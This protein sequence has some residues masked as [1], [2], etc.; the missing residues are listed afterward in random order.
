MPPVGGIGKNS[1]CKGNRSGF[2]TAIDQCR[3]A[4]RRFGAR[5]GGRGATC[6]KIALICADRSAASGPQQPQP[7]PL[8]W[9]I[10]SAGLPAGYRADLVALDPDA[11]Q[12]C[13][14]PGWPERGE[15]PREVM[16]SVALCVI[17]L[18]LLPG[19]GGP[20]ATRGRRRRRV[21]DC[22]D[23]G[24]RHRSPGRAAD[25]PGF[26]TESRFRADVISPKGAQGIAQ[27][28][29]WHRGERG[30]ADP[31]D[32]EQA[33]PKAARLIADFTRRFGNIGLAAAAYNAGP[34]RVAEL[35]RRLGDP[36]GGSM[37]LCL[38]DHR[39]YR[40]G[41]G[42]LPA[43]GTAARPADADLHVD[44]TASLRGEDHPEDAPLAPWERCSYRAIS[45]RQSPSPR[46]PGRSSASP[47]CSRTSS[48]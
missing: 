29:A 30:L 5:Y 25:A 36:A 32:P 48:R 35:A 2:G 28:L 12:G 20:G 38:H 39:P 40:R 16:R 17:G 34:N 13:S 7:L 14:A 23:G 46:S 19:D 42:G 8:A 24:A 31:F 44:V 1:P 27:F 4:A 43:A 47:R 21:S 11:V 33:I 22:R 10:G 9:T 37:K 26:W 18:L 41:L 45:R 6:V 15:A 3:R